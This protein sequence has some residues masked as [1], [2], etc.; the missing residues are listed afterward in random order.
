MLQPLLFQYYCS[1][2]RVIK[3][4]FCTTYLQ[5]I[6]NQPL[7]LSGVLSSATGRVGPRGSGYFKARDLLDLRHYKG[8][9]SSTKCTGRFYPRRNPWYSFSEA[10][11]NSGYM[12]LSEGTTEKIP[13]DTTGDR[14]RDR[15]TSSAVH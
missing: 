8:D 10:E 13:S 3:T 11:S 6:V 14:S 1:S 15:P 12:V 7:H 9:R 4:N 2:I 5:S